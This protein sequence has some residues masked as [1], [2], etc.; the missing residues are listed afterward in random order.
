MQWAA[1]LLAAGRLKVARHEAEQAMAAARGHVPEE[2]W[3]VSMLH[4]VHGAASAVGGDR[5]G[6]LEA[7][8]AQ[9]LV[10]RRYP[11]DSVWRSDASDLL[12]L[13]RRGAERPAGAR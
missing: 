5:G 12:A 11:A 13:A 9:V 1:A 6:V 2:D 4:L 7:E 10:D 3:S 8:H